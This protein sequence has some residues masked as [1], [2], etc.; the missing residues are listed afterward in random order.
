MTYFSQN[1][2]FFFNQHSVSGTSMGAYRERNFIV[3]NVILPNLLTS[4]DLKKMS[5]FNNTKVLLLKDV[6]RY[7][8]EPPGV[9]HFCKIILNIYAEITAKAT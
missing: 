6:L 1:G 4:E 9:S 7:K 2:A 3:L 8:G 5:P